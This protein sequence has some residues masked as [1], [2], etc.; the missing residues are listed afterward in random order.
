MNE[1]IEK[2]MSLLLNHFWITKDEQK[3]EYYFLKQNQAKI[4]EFVSKNLGNKL[5]VHDRFIKLEKTPAFPSSTLGIYTFYDPMDYVILFLCLL[6]LEDKPRGEKFILSNLIEYIKNTAITLE[7][8]HIPNW[9]ITSHRKC[10]LRVLDYLILQ[11][12]LIIKDREQRRFEDTEEADALYEVTGLANYLLPSFDCD[13]K[14]FQTPE[15]FLKSEWGNQTV[16]KG[17]VRRFK[18]YRH[19]LYMPATHK[20]HWTESEE[21]YFKKVHRMIE[22]EIREN[23]NMEVE[24]TKN[25]AMLYVDESSME[26]EYFPNTK[27]ISDIILLINLKVIEYAKEKNL[28]LDE[29]ECFKI[30]KKE[31]LDLLAMVR[32]ENTDYFSKKILDLG[33]KKYF[34]EVIWYMKC[35]EMIEE[36]E[37]YFILYPVIYRFIAKIR[38]KQEEENH[39][40]LEVDFNE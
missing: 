6:F 19:L 23:L 25:M 10:L 15:D 32:E 1:S 28:F 24:I 3:E 35:L 13:I 14:S 2:E 20:K 37:E 36:R 9:T 29:T 22:K 5:I 7:L 18:V 8:N 31:F 30:E 12:I 26:K 16:D 11:H 38:K 40:Q 39:L 34:D 4:K 27:N 21:D 33:I 17:D